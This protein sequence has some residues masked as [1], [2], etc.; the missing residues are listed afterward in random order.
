M[1]CPSCGAQNDSTTKFCT[2]CGASLAAAQNAG[3]LK[4]VTAGGAI[5]G[6]AARAARLKEAVDPSSIISDRAYNGAI[7]AMLLWGFLVNYLLCLKV[8]SFT[9]IFPNMSPIAFFIGYFVL[10][11]SGII[12]TSKASSPVFCFIGYNLLVVPLGLVVSTAVEAYGG[13]SS[14]VVTQAFLYTLLIAV[15]MTATAIVFPQ[16]FEKIGGA[17]AATLGCLILAE[18]IL[19]I[20]RVNQ[21]VTSWI[22]AG[23]FSLYLGYDVYRSQQFPRTLKNA[24][25]S[26]LDIYLDLVNIFLRLLEILGRRRD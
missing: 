1:K 6:K 21:Q 17:L 20:F 3:N 4:A 2:S 16:L 5:L 19:L 24:I 15:A 25:R 7:G 22:A 9:N 26:A 12:M 8:G 23:L 18:V 11:L 10:A 13:V 14:V